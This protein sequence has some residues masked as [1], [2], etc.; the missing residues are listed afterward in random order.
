MLVAFS[1]I[2]VNA[3]GVDGHVNL[4]GCGIFII[5][6]KC[7]VE[8]FKGAVQPAVTQMLDTEINKGMLS[9]FVNFVICRHGRASGE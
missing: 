4:I 1:V 8:I 7:T 5:K 6:G 2:G 9:F 3:V